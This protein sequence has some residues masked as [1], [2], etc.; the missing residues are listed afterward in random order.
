MCVPK[1]QL[2]WYTVSALC[3]LCLVL[4]YYAFC[5]VQ[6]IKEGEINFPSRVCISQ[7]GYH[8]IHRAAAAAAAAVAAAAVA[9]APTRVGLQVGRWVGRWV[10][11]LVLE[12]LLLLQLSLFVALFLSLLLQQ[13]VR[14]PSCP[15]QTSY[16]HDRSHACEHP[17]ARS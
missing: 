16:H 17:E 5:D 10:G 8:H 6:S 7:I 15:D 9:V 1:S 11:A 3:L 14:E 12:V 13:S 4:Q 2:S